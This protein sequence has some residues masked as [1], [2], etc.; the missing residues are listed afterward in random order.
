MLAAP[1]VEKLKP[2]R[3]TYF[4]TEYL[5]WDIEDPGV[6]TLGATNNTGQDPALGAVDP[7]NPLDPNDDIVFLAPSH[8]GAGGS[9]QQRRPA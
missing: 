2:P 8:L 5:L 4:R 3:G 6:N 9:R 1:P 7:V